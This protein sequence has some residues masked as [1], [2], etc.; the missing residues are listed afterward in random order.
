MLARIPKGSAGILEQACGTGI[1]TAKI[2]RRFP[3]C[4]VTGVD[5][6]KEYLAVAREKIV[7]L[8]LPN[9]DFVAGKAEDVLLDEN[10]DCIVS[11]YLAKYADLRAL[12]TG[13]G[14]ML[15]D[16]GT[17]IMHDFTYPRRRIFAALW[18]LHFV[19]LQTV[20]ARLYPQW[21]PAFDDLPALL[22]QTTWVE[23]LCMLLRENGFSH[24]TVKSLTFGSAAIVTGKKAGKR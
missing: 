3:F 11:S 16:E 12:V 10:F 7:T 15:R 6:E 8:G 17:L 21:K 20:G 13:A 5:M 9:V 14:S 23:D 19:L 4:R 1:L 24:V 2:A 18:R 22:R